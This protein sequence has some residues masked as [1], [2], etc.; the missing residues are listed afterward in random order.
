ML[1]WGMLIQGIALLLFVFASSFFHFAILSALLG[2]GTAMVY[3]TFLATIAENTHPF[4]RAKSLG[5]FRLWRDMGYAIG[6]VI[7]GILADAFNL[8]VSIIAIAALTLISSLMI[9]K[10]M[11]CRTQSMKISDWILRKIFKADRKI[12]VD[13]FSDTCAKSQTH[14]FSPHSI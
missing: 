6:A 8:N 7:T 14:S 9:E 4:D 10:R 2:W 1:F 12:K 13:V 3:P 11:R 5:V